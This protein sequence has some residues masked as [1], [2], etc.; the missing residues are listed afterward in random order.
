MEGSHAKAITIRPLQTMQREDCVQQPNAARVRTTQHFE[1]PY[2]RT[3]SF[4]VVCRP[5]DRG[6]ID[7]F[8]SSLF[9]V[10]G[11]NT[12]TGSVVCVA[13]EFENTRTLDDDER[14]ID[15]G[16]RTVDNELW[17]VESGK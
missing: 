7:G 13:N 12:R 6:S 1:L 11:L 16:Q 17:K 9:G 5:M 15:G 4:T 2:S 14:T 10:C 3:E 8:A